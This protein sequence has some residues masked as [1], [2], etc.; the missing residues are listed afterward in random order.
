MD[1]EI[2]L[3]TEAVS[4]NG[5]DSPT[6]EAFARRGEAEAEER[7]CQLNEWDSLAGADPFQP[8]ECRP[9]SGCACFRFCHAWPLGALGALRPAGLLLEFAA[10]SSQTTRLRACVCEREKA[11]HD[12][13]HAAY[14]ATLD[15]PRR[16]DS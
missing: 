15:Q 14:A 5:S 4:R 1:T 12:D 2:A 13:R 16:R 7:R 6:W 9:P 10:G 3:Y 11:G 8:R